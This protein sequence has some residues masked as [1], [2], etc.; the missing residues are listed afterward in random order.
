MQQLIPQ[1]INSVESIGKMIKGFMVLGVMRS[2]EQA[3]LVI[4]L[5]TLLGMRGV[6]RSGRIVHISQKVHSE[7]KATVL[8]PLIKVVKGISELDSELDA[9]YKE[10][11]GAKDGKPKPTRGVAG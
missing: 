8:R 7:Y 2:E 5:C 11:G 10:K 3:E 9:F 1:A 6:T 4:E